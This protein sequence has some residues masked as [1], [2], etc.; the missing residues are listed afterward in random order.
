MQKTHIAALLLL[1]LW[2]LGGCQPAE[3]VTQEAAAPP[4]AKNVILLIGDGMGI[5]QVS[6][7]FYLSEKPT[8]FTRFQYIGLMNTSSKTHQITDSGAGGTAIATGV[9]TYNGAIGV[10]TDTAAV[11]SMLEIAAE[12]GCKT[13]LIAT[14]AITHAT[15]ASFY[16]HVKSRNMQED[17]AT[18]LLDAPVHFFAGGG[19]KF[20]ASRKDE[21]DLFPTLAERGYVIDSAGLNQPAQWDFDKKYGYLL[22]NDGMPRMLDGRGGFSP[23]ATQM[24]IGYL[25]QHEKGFFMMIEGSQIDWAGHARDAEYMRTEMLDF[26]ETMGEVLNFAQRDGNTLV[27]VTADHETGGYTLSSKKNEAGKAD[28]NILDPAFAN[29][30]HSAALVPVFAFGPGAEEF[31]GIYNNTE[32]IK[33]ILATTSW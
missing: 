5:S 25:S 20:F 17:I 15:P 8:N 3:P 19:T 1:A 14:S 30:G 2:S 4:K 11:K 10:D 16:A 18:Q 21:Q 23:K 29:D 9:R 24:A 22:A 7:S 28:Y 26:D 6:A 12:K 33:K 27:I 31:I 13:G 32:L